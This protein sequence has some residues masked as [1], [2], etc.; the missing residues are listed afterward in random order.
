MKQNIKKIKLV[1]FKA[2]KQQSFDFSNLTVFCGNNSVGKST[3]I[4]AIG[5]FLQSGLL[6]KDALKLNGELVH[7]GNLD[8]IHNYSNRD[9]EHLEIEMEF[10]NFNISW[11]Y[12]GDNL[13]LR[14]NVSGKDFLSVT[15]DQ[16]KI[17]ALNDY[18]S[19]KFNF[20]FMEAERY[21]PRDNLALSQHHYHDNWLGKKGEYTIEIL[22]RLR[23]R[24]A[25]SLEA[26]DVRIH[27]N[28]KNNTYI[29]K[30]IEAWMSEISPGHALEP[31]IEVRANVAYNS[32]M[33]SSGQITKPINIGYG[34]SYA[35]S[36]VTALM[37]SSPGDLVIIENPEAHL[38]P[39]GQSYLG[40]LIALTAQSGIQVII[41]THSDHLLNGIR[42]IARTSEGFDPEL[43]S[44]YYISNTGN[45]ADAIKININKEGKLSSWPEGFFD[46]QSIDM[47]TIMTGNQGAPQFN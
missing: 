34:Y 43:F 17:S 10:S 16:D 11:G 31:Q 29:F 26:G 37:I 9:E 36:V 4:Q 30:N 3:A 39:R 23:S 13:T 40:R 41:E 44:L 1:N 20:Q 7:I 6:S 5:L 15:K 42:V 2:Y 47:Y 35:L 14:E 32:I 25:L 45:N 27:F 28:H 19:S 12:G 18:L 46:Q 8:D 21:G 33:T 38:H 24:E 22:E